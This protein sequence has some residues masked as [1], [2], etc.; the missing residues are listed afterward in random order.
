MRQRR[1]REA[2]LADI[3]KAVPEDEWQFTVKRT[4]ETFGWTVFHTFDSRRSD[5]GFPDLHLLR[6][7]DRRQIVIECKKDGEQPTPAQLNYLELFHRCGVEAWVLR[8]SDRDEL[9]SILR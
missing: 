7:R 4:A 6:E 8:P 9:E 1:R 2:T 5:I 3:L